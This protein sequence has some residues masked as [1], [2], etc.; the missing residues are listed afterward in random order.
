MDTQQL[1]Q[2]LLAAYGQIA[3]LPGLRFESHGCA[4]LLFEKSIAVDLEI[5]RGAGC[6]QIY[7]VL[8]P[9]PAGDRESLYRR[10]LEANLFGT[11]TH[12]ATLSIDGVQDEMLLSR[13]VDVANTNAATFAELL[14]SFAG[15]VQQW[16]QKV[17]SGE[18]VAASAAMPDQRLGM[19]QRA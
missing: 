11:E 2:D 7:G 5:D 12:G 18:L 13:R 15:V 17:G 1:A 6:L 10:L 8:G 9:V 14:E 3:G 19:F 4:R 16:Q